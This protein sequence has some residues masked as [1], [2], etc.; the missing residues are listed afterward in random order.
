MSRLLT[1]Q[2]QDTQEYPR[3]FLISSYPIRLNILLHGKALTVDQGNKVAREVQHFV[4]KRDVLRVDHHYV[5]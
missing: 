3:I 2:Y 4:I 1:H 5:D